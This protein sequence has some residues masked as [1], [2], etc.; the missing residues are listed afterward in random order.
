MIGVFVSRLCIELD[1]R[2]EKEEDDI[3]EKLRAV[4]QAIYLQQ[5]S[6]I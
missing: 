1:T 2:D 3:P 4:W 6:D 5:R